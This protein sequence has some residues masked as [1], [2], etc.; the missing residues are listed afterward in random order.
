MLSRQ[1]VN[2]SK[3]HFATVTR[4]KVKPVRKIQNTESST[5]DSFFR[6]TALFLISIP[7]SISVYVSYLA[8]KRN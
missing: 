2:Q 3:R 4:M 7:L 6:N 8:F 5:N 1:V